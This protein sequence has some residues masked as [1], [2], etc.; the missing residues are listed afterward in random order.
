[1]RRSVTL[2]A[3][4][5]PIYLASVEPAAAGEEPILRYPL[6]GT[7]YP[8]NIAPPTWSWHGG[9]GPWRV[10]V[11]ALDGPPFAAIAVVSDPRFTPDEAAWAAWRTVLGDGRARVRVVDEATD[12]AGPTASFAFAEPAEG[13]VVFRQVTAPFWADRQLR[14]RLRRQAVS[15]PAPLPLEQD[16]PDTPC[17][18]CH[19]ASRDGG[20]LAMQVRDPYDP[21]TDLLRTG[22]AAPTP[23]ALPDPPFGRTS[24][25][26]WTPEGQLVVAMG[27]ELDYQ[28]HP[29]GL[30]LTHHAS[31]LALVDPA[32]ASWQPIPGAS[33]PAAVE[34][35]PDVSPDG[36]TLAF[37]RGP[38]LDIET[39][40]LDIW[41]VPLTGEGV[42]RP[43][44]GASGGGGAH[45]F[46][47]HSP[48]GRWIA[49][50]RTGGG[51]FARPDADLYLVP[52]A[53][54]LARSLEVNVPDRMDS[55]PSWSLDGHWLVYASRRDDP[56]RTRAYLT[57]ID[58]DGHASPP[59]P[60]PGPLPAGLSHNHPTFTALPQVDATAQMSQHPEKK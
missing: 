1:M 4:L 8:A 43:L 45:V 36:R 29:D 2:M 23:L 60:L 58:D 10:E 13:T 3:A 12:A 37:V 56:D 24:G 47:R 20:T 33:D 22:E 31:D 34:D 40:E 21:H 27:L 26:A 30:T 6:D 44:D 9:E 55:W 52:A 41:T 35:F 28:V 17:R 39:G 49:F 57:R 54:G 51:Y 16:L 38:V 11:A 15:D 5:A 50:V 32:S 53:G 14:T 7:L 48:D 59:V 19:A 18:G 46:P 25:L 42:A